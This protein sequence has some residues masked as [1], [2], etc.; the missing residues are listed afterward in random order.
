M[1]IPSIRELLDTAIDKAVSDIHLYAKRPGMDFSRSRK[2]PPD[3]L[4]SFLIAQGSSPLRDCMLDFFGT[5]PEIASVQALCQQRA[6]L[7]PEAVRRVFLELVSGIEAC[8]PQESYRYLAADGTTLT[9]S[10]TPGYSGSEFHTTQGG[11]D[12]SYS[13]HLNAMYD[14]NAGIYTDGVIQPIRQMDEYRAFCT[15]VDRCP[16]RN[17]SKTVFIGDRGYCSY[18]NMAHVI[19]A[20]QY[21]LFRCK[22]VDSKGILLN[23]GLPADAPQDAWVTY[24]LVRRQSK[25]AV[26]GLDGI[27]RFVCRNISF[28]YIPPNSPGAYRLAFRIVRFRL[29]DGSW[30][31][32]V[33]NLP[34]E[35][36]PPE[37]IKRI[38]HMR[39]SVE[40]SFRKL[41]YTMAALSF[42]TYKPQFVQQEI[43]AALA[44]YNLTSLAI[45]EA[46]A[47]HG[48]ARKHEYAVNF[49]AAAHI[50]RTYLQL[51]HCM[52]EAE[53]L[54][55]I[56]RF[57]QP[58]RPDRRY[59]RLSTAHF[60][61]P[62]YILYRP[63]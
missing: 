58:V 6:K 20:G 27:V 33:T 4:L 5:S 7:D 31:C 56:A 60:R 45:I 26:S 21:F 38:Y 29:D 50:T 19:E 34:Q 47:G 35:E 51:R 40:S 59:K 3:V 1:T 12:G 36:F 57:L 39:W 63:A 55:T 16:G 24:T 53:M 28:D 46:P 37:R 41:K 30:E 49:N 15:M 10:S 11:K 2:I 8:L 48:G 17:G 54:R 61:R 44:A 43:W 14:I 22:D 42:H 9:F 18:N 13:V 52:D 25:K 32:I 62:K 23:L